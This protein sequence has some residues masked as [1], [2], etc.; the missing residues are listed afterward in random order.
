MVNCNELANWWVGQL[1]TWPKP[2]E[3][4]KRGIKNSVIKLFSVGMGDITGGGIVT[5]APQLN[6]YDNLPKSHSIDRTLS[7]HPWRSIP[8]FC[9]WQNMFLFFI[10]KDVTAERHWSIV[11]ESLMY[12][13]RPWLH[14]KHSIWLLLLRNL[15]FVNNLEMMKSKT[16]WITWRTYFEFYW[17][18]W[19]EKGLESRFFW[20]VLLCKSHHQ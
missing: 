15:N 17:K 4:A 14:F 20:P 3:P 12:C 1:V 19:F 11:A 18:E 7:G 10:S 8:C 5:K 9:F 13:F 2:F 16:F 6:N